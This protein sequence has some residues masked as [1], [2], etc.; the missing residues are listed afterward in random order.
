MLWK[1]KP[2]QGC[3]REV[4][5]VCN[6]LR[7]EAGAKS[8]GLVLPDGV[9]TENS[10]NQQLG[11]H[12]VRSSC[13]VLSLCKRLSGLVLQG[14]ISNLK[15]QI[16]RVVLIPHLEKCPISKACTWGRTTRRRHQ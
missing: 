16:S 12:F 14:Q 9:R 1:R 6:E 2:R 13:P 4:G 5:G 7:N 11:A 8:K 3:V 10:L 15:S